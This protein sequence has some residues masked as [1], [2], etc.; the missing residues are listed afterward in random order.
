MV[1]KAVRQ[2]VRTEPDVWT[3][4]RG[5]RIEETGRSRQRVAEVQM[6]QNEE[7]RTEGMRPQVHSQ[8]HPSESQ[9]EKPKRYQT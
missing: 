6:A 7:S 5:D 8:R 1:E 9:L 3:V 2:Q 4:H